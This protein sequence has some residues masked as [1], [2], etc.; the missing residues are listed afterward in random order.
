MELILDEKGQ[1]EL[2]RLWNEFEFVGDITARTWTQYFFN[3]SGEVAGK[4]AESGTPRPADHRITDEPVVL[5]MRDAYL[6][7]AAANPKQ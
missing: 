3:Q 2:N 4:G 6:A 7:K 5:A 1:A